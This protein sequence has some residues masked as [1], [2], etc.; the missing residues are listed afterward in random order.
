MLYRDGNN[1]YWDFYNS[2]DGEGFSLL[3]NMAQGGVMP[4]IK[5]HFGE[6]VYRY[7]HDSCLGTHDTFIDG[8]PQFMQISS[9]KVYGF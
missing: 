3:L 4:G 7:F 1:D 9:V 6:L 5:K 8:Q 2:F